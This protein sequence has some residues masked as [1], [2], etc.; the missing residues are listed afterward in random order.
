MPAPVHCPYGE[1]GF[2]GG[3]AFHVWQTHAIP[4]NDSIQDSVI[5]VCT[6]CGEVQQRYFGE[7]WE[8]WKREV[9]ND[10]ER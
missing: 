3:S 1:D 8:T 7:E 6:R 5:R 2:I 9:H 4:G 10:T